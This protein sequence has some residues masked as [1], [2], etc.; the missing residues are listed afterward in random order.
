[1][2]IAQ[3]IL[4]Y[5][6]SDDFKNNYFLMK[7]RIIYLAI[8][9]FIISTS[10]VG[11]TKYFKTPKGIIIMVDISNIRQECIVDQNFSIHLSPK[12]QP[13]IIGYCLVPENYKFK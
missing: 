6:E 2:N 5:Y 1:M 13:K 10:V 9:S 11:Q 3:K 12:F 4:S 8:M 7:T